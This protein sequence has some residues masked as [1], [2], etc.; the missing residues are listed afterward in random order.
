MTAAE[1]PSVDELT[2]LFEN[3][4][5]DGAKAA[6]AAKN[7]KISTLLFDILRRAGVTSFEERSFGQLLY[8]LA[9]KI[10]KEAMEHVDFLTNKIVT[11]QIKSEAQLLVALKYAHRTNVVNESTFDAEC[12]VG[13]SVT[14]AEIEAATQ[15]VVR[16]HAAE[17]SKSTHS[18][19]NLLREIKEEGNVKWAD[20][21]VVKEVL[22]RTLAAFDPSCEND[23]SQQANSDA[24]AAV[25]SAAKPEFRQFSG[26]VLR[27][28]KPGQNKQKNEQI[29]QAHLKATGGKVI[30]RFPPEPNGF[31]HAGHA[32]AINLNF[33]YAEAHNGH[34]YLRFDDTNPE[35]EEEVY[36]RSIR[37]SV[38]W[39]GF[40]PWKVTHASD[41]FDELYAYAVELIKRGKAYICHMTPEEIKISRGGDN[42]DLPRT[43]SPWRNRPIDESL[44][45]FDEMRCGLHAEGSAVLRMKQD[46]QSANPFMWDLVAYRIIKKPHVRTG[47]KWVIYPTYD[48]THCLNDS[49]E[50][51]THSLCT[52]EFIAAHE[53]YDWVCDA[54]DVY[55]AFQWEYG[56]LNLT[57]TI[58]SKRKLTKLVEAGIVDGWDD[59]R[60]Y[61]IAGIRRRG[62][63]P[64]A[65]NNFVERIG[66]TTAP[67][68][69]DIRLL[70]AC[71]REDLNEVAPR[72]MAILDPI[73]VTIVNVA[74]NQVEC[75]EMP[76]FPQDAS[77][78]T[79]CVPFTK[80][81]FIDRNDFM[82]EAPAA[83]P[84][85]KRLVVGGTVGLFKACVI[86][87]TSFEVDA[88]TGAVTHIL[89][90]RVE[91]DD[92]SDKVPKP[93]TFIQWVADAPEWGSPVRAEVR[94]Y[95]DLFKSRNPAENPD[96][97]LADVNPHS[98]VVARDAVVDVRVLGAAPEE[99]FQFQR[100]GFFCVDGGSRYA[101]GDAK[102]DTPK[103]GVL[104]F[105][106]TVSLKEDAAKCV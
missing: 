81:I 97:W 9:A 54:L 5:L 98:L 18:V 74:D 10:T 70:E 15:K 69:V 50:N 65:I 40:K 31:L 44:R 1:M 55:K 36:F 64:Q 13:V 90:E 86:R 29:M 66:I 35:A 32:K 89:A 102:S 79:S 60:L 63:T 17:I 33:R 45:L 25:T 39:L 53:C 105:N 41:Y 30:T 58:L 76:N 56:R 4:G 84:H 23:V 104:R 94:L 42:K 37:E 91:S 22:E 92:G 85:Y 75:I 88:A 77:R 99:K 21:R 43:D 68:T 78:G 93:K 59:P 20:G 38:E 73:R 67:T 19:G 51:I 24:D 103:D 95:A 49:L 101:T 34:C 106:R 80:H 6:E 83:D 12:G 27:L 7:K 57:G 82:P 46:M 100:V 87:C 61:T 62:F 26:D 48:F 47:D 71:V 8:L 52:T 96:G 72:V 3:I 14:N 16:L 28:H 2:M 11:R